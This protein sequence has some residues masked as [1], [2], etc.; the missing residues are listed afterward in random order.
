MH[1]HDERGEEIRNA[2]DGGTAGLVAPALYRKS[3]DLNDITLGNNNG[4][5]AG[6]GWDPV[7]GLGSPKG[8]AIAATLSE[9]SVRS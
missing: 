3:G 4:F 9:A 1:D 6:P 2:G 7:T 5:E 8:D